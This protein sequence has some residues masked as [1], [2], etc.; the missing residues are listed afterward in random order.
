MLH[1]LYDGNFFF[2]LPLC[3]NGIDDILGQMNMKLG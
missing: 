3:D 1:A 2:F